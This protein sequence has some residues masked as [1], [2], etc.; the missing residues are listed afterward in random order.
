MTRRHTD[1]V[2]APRRRPRARTAAR[3]GLA[4]LACAPAACASWQREP[5]GA[6]PAAL[7]ARAADS[8]LRVLLADGST[9][10][11]PAQR[12]VVGDSLV[13]GPARARV[14]VALADVRAVEV[15]RPD[16]RRTVGILLLGALAAVIVFVV[17]AAND[18]GYS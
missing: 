2:G 18:L 6:A 12:A 7:I 11:V 5:P 9:V 16:E 10:R 13:G 4:W 8:P 14:A 15:R 3:L 1:H 17:H